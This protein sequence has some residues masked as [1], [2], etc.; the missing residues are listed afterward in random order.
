MD[1]LLLHCVGDILEVDRDKIVI[2]RK[3]FSSFLLHGLKGTKTIPIS[4]ISALQFKTANYMTNGYI[5]FTVPGGNES[6]GGI[7]SAAKDENS[8]LF[9]K[10]HLDEALAI[11]DFI[12]DIIVHRGNISALDGEQQE[13]MQSFSSADEILKFKVLMDKGIITPE[14]FIQKKKK[15]LGM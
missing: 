12:E 5:Q 7:I 3:G 11:K 8:V 1:K 6:K 14:E 15:L 9:R 13:Q 4:S 2:T 10:E